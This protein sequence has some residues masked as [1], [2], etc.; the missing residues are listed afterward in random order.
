[1]SHAIPYPTPK[2]SAHEYNATTL[3]RTEGQY[4]VLRDD[5]PH[6]AD[7]SDYPWSA[8]G[9]LYFHDP[10]EGGDYICTAQFIID[11]HVISTA[12]H[13]VWDTKEKIYM[14]KHYFH[15]GQVL[16][17]CSAPENGWIGVR[18]LIFILRAC[19]NVIAI[20]CCRP[21]PATNRLSVSKLVA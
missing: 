2:P 13:C 9:K 14:T 6:P 1:M 12:G 4:P 17:P 5:P 8:M 7:M 18:G 19:V 10:N 16:W 15:R 21:G 3:F 20:I 11:S